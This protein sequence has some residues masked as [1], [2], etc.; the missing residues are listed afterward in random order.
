MNHAISSPHLS[1][2]RGRTK[3]LVLQGTPFC[4]IAC[5]YC[6][7]PDR[8]SSVRMPL[9]TIG[10]AVR[11]I[12][13][14]E[15]AAEHLT[16]VWHAGEPLTLP[17]AWYD[18]AFAAAK[19]AA[20]PD[21]V[22]RHAIQTNGMLIDDE[23]CSLFAR[24][25]IRV[26]VSLDGPEEL[27]DLHRRMR[28]GRGT[29]AATMRGITALKR[30]RI[31]F[32]VICVV[33]EAT[34]SH[35]DALMDFFGAQDILDV[36]FN[37]EEVEGVNSSSTLTGEDAV[38]SRF[39]AFFGRVV[40]RAAA[41]GIRIREVRNVLGALVDMPDGVWRGND[42]NM[43]FAIVTVTHDGALHTF[44]P[45][46]AGISHARFGSMVLG[47]VGTD[48]LADVLRGDRFR[49]MWA[50]ISAGIDACERTCAY[51]S[52]CRGGAPSNKLAELGTFAGTETMAC[53][54]GNQEISEVILH[55]ILSEMK[56]DSVVAEAS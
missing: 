39:R 32:H 19:A 22:P 31:P 43:P 16:L 34:L 17:Q 54:L 47:N 49:S 11:W 28:N 45:E 30:N 10:A 12:F 4:N 51:F 53:R 33:T 38:R 6:Y 55:R 42:Q 50:E 8:N 25:S 27:H 15:L 29:H 20:P 2:L 18:S 24:H 14:N 48:S 41:F 35:P 7:L 52:L 40:D 1:D 46:L 56:R 37:I 44:S 9:A 21:W 3:L 23:W 36:G 26:G 13:A 5:D